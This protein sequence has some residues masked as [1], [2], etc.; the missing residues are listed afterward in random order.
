MAGIAGACSGSDSDEN[1]ASGS[2][3]TTPA[4]TSP[5]TAAPSAPSGS[6]TMPVSS[7]TEPVGLIA[8]GHSGLTAENSDP[9]KPGQSAFEN[10][11]A[12]GTADRLASIYQRMVELRPET[13]GHVANLAQGGA[14]AAS[15]QR[16]AMRALEDVPTPELAIIQT[17]DG[18]IRCD[19]SDAAHV[20]EFGAA[21]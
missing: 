12:T 1:A 4:P 5:A 16:Q 9:A 11:W 13:E 10:S 14:P 3:S 17:I 6:T 19:G 7:R 21:L 20:A 15:L 18:D 2:S 8:L